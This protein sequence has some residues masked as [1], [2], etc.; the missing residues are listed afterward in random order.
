VVDIVDLNNVRNHFGYA[1]SEFLGDVTDDQLVGIDD[2]NAVRNYFGATATPPVAASPGVTSTVTS[3][4]AASFAVVRTVLPQ[5]ALNSPP[6]Y[7][8]R[9]KS[10]AI[11]A[12]QDV[13][14]FVDRVFDEPDFGPERRQSRRRK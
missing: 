2:L 14:H 8:M 10:I 5:A 6:R 7:G 3:P 11:S 9:R 4:E 12:P 1:G 13:L